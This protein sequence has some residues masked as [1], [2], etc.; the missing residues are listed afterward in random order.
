[1]LTTSNS[2]QYSYLRRLIALPLL[3]LTIVLFSFRLKEKVENIPSSIKKFIISKD[4]I[5]VKPAKIIEYKKLNTQPENTIQKILIDARKEKIDTAIVP[6]QETPK[7]PGGTEGWQQF[8]RK[9]INYGKIVEKGGGPGKYAVD[10]SF[11]IDIDGDV[12]DVKALNDPG[13][14][15][16]EDAMRVLL[17]SP[18]WTPAMVNGKKVVYQNKITITYM[19][20]E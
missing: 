10:L 19:V 4:N 8:L 13:Y 17:S 6:L 14:G 12:R 5:T 2:I 16:K 18:K 15:S 1:M 7:F 20:S 9:T 11:I 3:L